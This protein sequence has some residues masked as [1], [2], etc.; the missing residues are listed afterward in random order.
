MDSSCLEV[1]VFT[2]ILLLEQCRILL[3]EFARGIQRILMT[4]PGDKWE[5]L[6]RWGV[7]EVICCPV[8]FQAS[9]KIAG[10][11]GEIGWFPPGINNLKF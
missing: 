5:S 9:K 10:E 2:K 11:F 3:E 6:F 7:S 1:G 4:S 8:G